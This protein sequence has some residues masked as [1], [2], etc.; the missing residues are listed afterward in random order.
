MEEG[1]TELTGVLVIRVWFEHPGLRARISSSLDI[2][3]TAE[4]VTVVGSVG[5]IQATVAEWLRRFTNSAGPV[6]RR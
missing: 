2:E 5:E 4:V 1:S 6:T 3:P